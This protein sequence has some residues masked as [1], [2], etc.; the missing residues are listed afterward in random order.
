MTAHQQC[1]FWKNSNLAK[2]CM[3]VLPIPKPPCLVKYLIQNQ[4]VINSIVSE[5]IIENLKN[6]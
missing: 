6:T 2:A 4:L 1:Y 5:S 3:D